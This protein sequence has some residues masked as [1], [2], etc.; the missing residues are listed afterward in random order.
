MTRLTRNPFLRAAALLGAVLLPALTWAGPARAQ[1]ADAT[2]E[3]DVVDETGVALPGVSVELK[4]AETGFAR[5]SVTSAA[6]AA[7]FPAIPPAAGYVARV[8]LQGFEA[9]E[10]PL[11]L[12]I[13]QTARLR[14]VL[15]AQAVTEAVTVVGEAPLVDV[16]KID[17]STNIVPE[18]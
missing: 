8:A 9:V 4:R 3:V 16:Y 14:V 17:S 10:Q 2:V 7:R 18:Q 15:R 6:G 12:R 13:G 1:T 11:T 5:T